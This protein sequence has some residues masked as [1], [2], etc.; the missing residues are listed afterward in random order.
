MLPLQNFTKTKMNEEILKTLTK[1]TDQSTGK[2]PVD[3]RHLVSGD[4]LTLE[5]MPMLNRI[6]SPP[7]RPVSG[8]EIFTRNGILDTQ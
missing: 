5:F 3:Y 2:L 4:T 8:T 7:L 6:I 1:T